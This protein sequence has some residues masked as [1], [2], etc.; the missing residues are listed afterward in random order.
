VTD[1]GRGISPAL[2]DRL[3]KRFSQVD[4]SINRGHGGAG[5]GLAI[6]KGLV[7]LMGGSIGVRSAPGRGSTFWFTLEAP[8]AEQPRRDGEPNTFGPPLAAHIL[9][10]DDVAVNR[11]LVRAMLEPLGYTLEEA[12]SGQEAIAAAARQ[13][14]D[15]ILMDL[16][17]AGVDG[18]QATRQ[19]R[20][21]PGFNYDTPIVALSANVLAGQIAECRTAG[22]NDH[23]AKPIIP[24]ALVSTIARWTQIRSGPDSSVAGMTPFPNLPAAA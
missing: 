12:D 21:T 2:Q 5:L 14:F 9:V 16:Q 22:M 13:P 23:L 4:G 8:P 7:E 11:L 24:A 15:L 6:C 1:T 20:S 18:L 10:V 19:I 17:M 3:F